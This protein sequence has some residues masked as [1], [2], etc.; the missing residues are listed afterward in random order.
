MRIALINAAEI[1]NSPYLNMYTELFSRCDFNDYDIIEWRRDILLE[2]STLKN[3]I[4]FNYPSSISKNRIFKIIDYYKYSRFVINTIQKNKYDKLII[5]DFQIAIYLKDFLIKNYK[6][7]YII[8]VRDYN[9]IFSIF[10]NSISKLSRSCFFRVLSSRGYYEWL[11]PIENDLLTHNTT[12]EKLNVF[13]TLNTFNL[14]IKSDKLIRILTIGSLRN[15]QHDKK[16]IT[17]LNGNSNICF[18]YA[19]RGC[20]VEI[21]KEHKKNNNRII[22]LGPYNK[23]DEDSFVYDA[24]FINIT[25]PNNLSFNTAMSNRFYLSLILGVP[26]IVNKYSIQAY[27]VNKYNLG[28]VIDEYDNVSNQLNE[29]IEKFNLELFDKNRKELI[30]I[31][32]EELCDF[33]C[34]IL[35]MIKNTNRNGE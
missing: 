17:A 20:D 8:D 32:S 30:Q 3:I 2:S 28:I 16:L 29:Y 1:E 4:S 23:K 31:I 25:L 12:R 35:E 11:K 34:K 10:R 7:K 18:I 6:N 13:V 26:M 33:E 15:F 21:I 24:D 22:Y 5:F 14:S 27:Y 9:S 19:G